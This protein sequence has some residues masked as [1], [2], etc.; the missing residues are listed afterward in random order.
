MLK[1]ICPQ[2]GGLKMNIDF[3]NQYILA[4]F[5]EHPQNYSFYTLSQKLGLSPSIIDEL[6]CKLMNEGLLAYNDKKLLSL[7]PQGK[8]II[9]NDQADY[10]S[11]NDHP[12]EGNMINPSTALSLE[13]IY[14]PE[15]FLEKL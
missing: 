13:Q 2:Q 15:G 4:Y 7:T 3:L 14:I 5:K 1:T 10:L 11:F 6:I 9:L 8:T 12:P